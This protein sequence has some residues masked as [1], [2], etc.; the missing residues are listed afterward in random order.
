MNEIL[1]V[2]AKQATKSR[3]SNGN[4]LSLAGVPWKFSFFW[5]RKDEAEDPRRLKVRS[6]EGWVNHYLDVPLSY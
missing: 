3:D 6:G 5:N 4:V 2:L 1:S